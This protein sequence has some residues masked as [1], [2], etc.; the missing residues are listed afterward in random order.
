MPLRE[1][2][3]YD[4]LVARNPNLKHEEIDIFIKYENDFVR[5]GAADNPS[6]STDQID[7]LTQD[8]S[9]TVYAS[10]AGNAA[11]SADALPRIQ[12]EREVGCMATKAVERT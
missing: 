9:H 7:T 5:S 12:R 3:T 11:L 6:L 10:L 1:R 2:E 8:P 4:F